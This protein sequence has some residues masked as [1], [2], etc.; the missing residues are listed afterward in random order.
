MLVAGGTDEWSRLEGAERFEPALDRFTEVGAMAFP[1]AHH[2]ATLLPGGRVLVVGGE[3]Q[4]DVGDAT[5]FGGSLASSEYYDRA[6][7]AF[8]PGASMASPRALHTATRL[9]DGSILI[10]GGVDSPPAPASR[11]PVTLASAERF[12]PA[13]GEALLFASGFE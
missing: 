1:R 12:V 10:V 6:S 5:H 9:P 8:T 3:T 11:A 13:S 7:G 4:V 2:T